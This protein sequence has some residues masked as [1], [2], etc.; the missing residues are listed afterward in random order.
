MEKGK[1]IY[2]L[3]VSKGIQYEGKISDCKARYLY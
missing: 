1:G 2:S 3:A